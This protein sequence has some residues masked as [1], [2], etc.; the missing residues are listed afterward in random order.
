[1]VRSI[2][3]AGCAL[4]VALPLSAQEARLPA[5]SMELGQKYTKWFLA[6][7]ADSLWSRMTPE[8]KESH[9]DIDQLVGVMEQVA[10]QAGT[11]VEVLE[12]RY[13]TRN[14]KPQFWHT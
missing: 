5:D 4:V 1:M 14:G 9:G 3:V 6:Y 11:E 2:V 7:E 13:V 12:E 10:L 8:F